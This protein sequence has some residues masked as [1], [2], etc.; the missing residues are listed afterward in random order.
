MLA[1]NCIS[2]RSVIPCW[3]C[4]VSYAVSTCIVAV[5]RLWGRRRRVTWPVKTCWSSSTDLSSTPPRSSSTDQ[6]R[7][8]PMSSRSRTCSGRPRHRC[9]LRHNSAITNSHR[10]TRHNS[11]VELR[12]VDVGRCELAISL[13]DVKVN[14]FDSFLGDAKWVIVN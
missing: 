8:L 5:G 11:T 2:L 9:T 3:V 6:T 10:P 14:Q 7:Q 13:L 12:R 4:D 1:C